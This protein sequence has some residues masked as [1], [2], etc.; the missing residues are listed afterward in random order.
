M[1]L[2]ED[3][4][5]PTPNALYDQIAALQKRVHLQTL[6]RWIACGWDRA[7]VDE[8]ARIYRARNGGRPPI[9]EESTSSEL[10]REAPRQLLLTVV[11][12]SKALRRRKRGLTDPSEFDN[13][14]KLMVALTKAT[15]DGV[16]ASQAG[17]N[18]D[19]AMQRDPQVAVA[20]P[21][22]AAPPPKPERPPMV[23]PLDLDTELAALSEAVKSLPN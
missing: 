9:D 6:H 2:W 18:V 23:D 12:M 8:D 10:I 22:P 20:P 16:E 4:G 7:L 5:R 14:A 15:K 3:A 11:A 21:E 1:D 13:A 17:L 19:L